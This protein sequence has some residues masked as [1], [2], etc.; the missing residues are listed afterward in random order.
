MGKAALEAAFG[1]H[2]DPVP[3][4]IGQ[5]CHAFL[6]QGG[7]EIDPSDRGLSGDGEFRGSEISFTCGQ[8]SFCS[9]HAASEP[10]P[11]IGFPTGIE[12]KAVNTVCGAVQITA[13][14]ECIG[15]DTC[16]DRGIEARQAL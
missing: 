11:E 8:I 12:A 4:F 14:F 2:P 9:G 15:G 5:D 13:D 3:R 6:G 16:A 7:V 10:V 1:Q